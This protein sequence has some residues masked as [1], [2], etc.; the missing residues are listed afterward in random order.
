M[1]Y[2]ILIH[3]P[4]A[5][6]LE[7]S[8]WIRLKTLRLLIIKFLQDQNN[9][10]SWGGITITIRYRYSYNNQAFN[11]KRGLENAKLIVIELNLEIEIWQKIYEIQLNQL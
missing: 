5:Y 7:L 8:K 11:K 9:R 3:L 10:C 1:F 2:F 4:N 6:S